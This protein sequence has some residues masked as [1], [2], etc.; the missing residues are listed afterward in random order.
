MSGEIRMIRSTGAALLIVAF[1]AFLCAAARADSDL[2]PGFK[3]DPNDPFKDSN[4][5]Q[6][7]TP[8]APTPSYPGQPGY[9]GQSPTYP[10]QPPGYPGQQPGFPGQP[11]YPGMQPGLQQ[12]GI[13]PELHPPLKEMAEGLPIDL[14]QSVN[15]TLSYVDGAVQHHMTVTSSST[16]EGSFQTITYTVH[17]QPGL[18]AALVPVA[19]KFGQ[20]N[21]Q[22]ALRLKPNP[23]ADNAYIAQ[24]L[25]SFETRVLEE[26]L[27]LAASP[28]P[29]APPAQSPGSPMPGAPPPA[30]TTPGAGPSS[31][32]SPVPGN[33]FPHAPAILGPSSPLPPAAPPTSP[34]P[35]PPGP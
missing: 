10:G 1:A 3:A 34:V 14:T 33:G 9:P 7:G 25:K 24:E 32:P 17:Y 21:L 26:A 20:A 2:P 29:Q 15:A 31:G 12:Q 19:A 6:N 11:G 8:T 4:G 22:D 23:R 5:K 13:A 16:L 27:Q 35:P 28:P 30:P 18:E